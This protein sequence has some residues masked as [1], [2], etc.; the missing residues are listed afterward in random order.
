MITIY[1]KYLEAKQEYEDLLAFE[2]EIA[3]KIASP[4]HRNDMVQ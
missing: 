1:E 4:R 2:R 3:N